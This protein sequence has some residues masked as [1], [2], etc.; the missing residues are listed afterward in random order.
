M[1]TAK[2]H[3]MH[4]FYL[5]DVFVRAWLPH[6]HQYLKSKFSPLNLFFV[7][8]RPINCRRPDDA[9]AHDWLFHNKLVKAD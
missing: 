2:H 7:A 3:Q 8:G 1:S 5:E 9:Q 4:S 6:M